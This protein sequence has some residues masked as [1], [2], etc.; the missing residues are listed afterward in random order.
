ML[1]PRDVK[2]RLHREQSAMSPLPRWSSDLLPV[3]GV[4]FSLASGVASPPA[5]PLS[6]NG[7]DWCV[8]RLIGGQ[9]VLNH[10]LR[11]AL[12]RSFDHSMRHLE[13]LWRPPTSAT[14][15]T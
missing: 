4:A 8:Q 2:P 13:K 6:K 7:S 9:S 12:L 3:G 14:P 11:A 15:D 5:T 10:D 1:G